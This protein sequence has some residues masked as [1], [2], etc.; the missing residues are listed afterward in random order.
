MAEIRHIH[1]PLVT[2]FK[3]PD[4][5]SE[6]INQLLYG[7]RIEVLENKNDWLKI[8]SIHDDYEG[9]TESRYVSEHFQKHH[10][11]R[12]PITSLYDKPDFKIPVRH[13]LYFGSPLSTLDKRENGFIQLGNQGW[14]FEAHLMKIEDTLPDFVETALMFL[15]SPYQWGGRSAMGIDCSGLVQMAMMAAGMKCPRD[16]RQQA[17]ALGQS[18]EFGDTIQYAQ[19]QRGDLVFFKGHVG[20]MT[21]K[22]YIL[23]A[24]AR[25]MDT[26]IEPL[27]TVS[28][29]YDGIIGVRRIQA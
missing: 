18:I 11:V 25:S 24:T 4:P 16:S 29:F 1:A 12:V 9:F 15:H 8:R 6:T 28:D 2:V 14:V 26:R 13:P 19:I 22:D 23:N 20:I 17:D 10:K 7:E 21:D 3:N 5:S 27:E